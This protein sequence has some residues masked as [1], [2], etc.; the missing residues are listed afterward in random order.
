MSRNQHVDVSIQQSRHR[1]L[2]G[3]ISMTEEGMD[4][5]DRARR[6]G[7]PVDWHDHRV[8]PNRPGYSDYGATFLLAKDVAR[9]EAARNSRACGL[10]PDYITLEA[11]S[12]RQ[13]QHEAT[14]IFN[15]LRA[16]GIELSGYA[17]GRYFTCQQA[18][19]WTG[20]RPH[21]APAPAP[22]QLCRVRH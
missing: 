19:P 17:D 6:L 13:A 18:M 7:F 16:K 1:V 2:C 12:G 14:R 10:V 20:K 21:H 3:I 11:H 22:A 4:L 5:V 9:A 15:G 8:Y